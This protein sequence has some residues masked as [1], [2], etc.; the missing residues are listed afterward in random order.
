M[1]REIQRYITELR[2]TV[3]VAGLN[4]EIWWIY[5]EKNSRKKY[6]DTM[7]GYTMFFQTSIHAHFVALLVALYR[8]Y[9]KRS[10]TI[11][12]PGLLKLFGKND[13]ISKEALNDIRKLH[14]EAHNLW[15]KVSI[16]R[17]EVF[18]HR[19]IK[20]GV[21]K[22][23]KRAGVTPN[24]L[25]DLIQKTRVLLNKI[26]HEWDRDT[27]A[28]NLEASHDTINLLDDLTKLRQLRSRKDL[29][30]TL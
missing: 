14:Q 30:A 21:A 23:F 29:E 5:K 19:S 9:E 26:T 10:D 11:N 25:T 22:V 1:K 7:N 13:Y 3:T 6:V 4:Y 8:L 16:L 17:N 20:Y 24:E 28:F 27:H 2:D 18:G 15:I 12:I